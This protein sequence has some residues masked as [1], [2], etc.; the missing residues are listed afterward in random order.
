MKRVLKKFMTIVLIVAL[1]FALSGETDVKAATNPYPINGINGSTGAYSN[2]TWTVWKLVYE[3]LGI[4]LPGWGN[5]GSWYASARNAGY[6]VGS[7]P[8]A[9][10]I[11]VTSGH[12]AFV[13]AV[14]SDG[15]QVY[16][17]EGGYGTGSNLGYHEGYVNA[18]PTNLVG[19]I[20]LQGNSQIES[21]IIVNDFHVG[22]FWD[23]GFTI[24][25]NVT[26]NVGIKSVQYAVWTLKE[27]NGTDQ[28]DIVWYNGNCTDGNNYYWSRINISS[29]NN[30]KGAY[31][32]HAYMYDNNNK[33]HV[34][35]LDFDFSKG[36]EIY[37][38]NYQ[39]GEFWSGGFTV[40]VHTISNS[41]IESVRY[42]V[43]TSKAGQDDIKWYNGYCTDGNDYYWARINISDHNNEKDEYIVHAYIKNKDAKEISIS[44]SFNFAEVTATPTPKPTARPTE[45]PTLKP[46]ARPTEAPTLRPTAKP[47]EAPTVTPAVEPE[48]QQT[49]DPTVNPTINPVQNLTA[50]PIESISDKP[51][52][53]DYL[54]VKNNK[55]RAIT[56]K[57]NKVSNAKSYIIQYSTDKKFKKAVYIKTTKKLSCKIKKLKKGKNYWVRV[58]AVNKG[59][60]GVWSK[61]K[62]VKVKK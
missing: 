44:L 22:E 39:V 10:S 19:Y 56:V 35:T 43:W 16:V 21:E 62:K 46:T 36:G 34:E 32:I 48:V 55:K 40:M 54:S 1:C 45:A 25:S 61:V 18:Y 31:R 29:H 9:N 20:Y 30:E 5:A 26:S 12:V 41:T 50:K 51:V 11:K 6:S 24:L 37:Y 13:T 60:Q 15:K 57:Y 52:K 28:D 7:T 14:S 27:N 38:D 58:C 8:A 4:A 42:A 3:N 49:V 17:K 33:L 47:T 59:L 53:I 23:G 2:C